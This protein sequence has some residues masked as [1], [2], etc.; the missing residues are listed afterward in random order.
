MGQV[1]R[2]ERIINYARLCAECPATGLS[3]ESVMPP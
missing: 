3:E 1:A 2:R